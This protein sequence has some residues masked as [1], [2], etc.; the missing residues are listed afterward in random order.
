MIAVINDLAFQFQIYEERQAMEAVEKFISI[1]KELESVKCH[2]VGRVIGIEIDKRTEICP[3]STLF[4]IVQK[5]N[6]GERAY[7]LGLLANRARAVCLPERPFVYKERESFL[8]AAAKDEI[9][10][11]FE[12][13]EGLKREKIEGE[14]DQESVTIKNISDEKHLLLYREIV[15]LRIY[16]ENK[17]HKKDREN[18]YGKG[19]VASPM[20]LSDE[21]AQYLLDRANSIKG[22]LYAKKG[23]NYYAFQKTRECIYHG[24]IADD[25]GDD[26]KSAINSEKWD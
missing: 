2:N 21:E 19:K 6:R 20:D 24:Y 25:L 15:G 8:C 9:L 4:K 23:R 16:E 5:M 11:S 3:G 26:V 10:V 18:A 7:F 1:C 12:T 13:E 17:K 22:R 14:I